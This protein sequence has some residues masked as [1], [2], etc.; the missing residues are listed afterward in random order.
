M[1][2]VPPDYGSNVGITRIV[3]EPYL[4]PFR[5]VRADFLIA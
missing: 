3:M 1:Q 2:I 4:K 5:F